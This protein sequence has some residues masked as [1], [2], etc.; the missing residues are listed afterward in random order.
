MNLNI[1]PV[2]GHKDNRT[3]NIYDGIEVMKMFLVVGVKITFGYFPS[4][5]RA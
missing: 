2:P 5:P 1:K 4:M 3:D